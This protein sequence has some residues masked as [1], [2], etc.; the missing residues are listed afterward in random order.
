MRP[1]T[2]TLSAFGPYA[3]CITLSLSALTERGI[4][5]ITGDTGAGKTTLFDAIVYAL[6]G[7]SSGGRREPAMLR[8]KQAE[9]STP[10][11]VELTFSLGEHL[12]TVRRAP[13]YLRPAKRGGEKLISSPPTAELTMPTGEIIVKV[14]DVNA[15]LEELL[16]L[17]R[18]QFLQVAMIA[19]GDFL[20][21]LLAPTDERREI[22][23]RLF[24]TELYERASSLLR[25]EANALSRTRNEEKLLLDQVLAAIRAPDEEDDEEEE[26][27]AD[28]R[29]GALSGEATLA[30]LARLIAKD[31]ARLAAGEAEK[32]AVNA[33]LAALDEEIRC[34]ERRAEAEASLAKTEAALAEAR[35]TVAEA[36]FRLAGETEKESVREGQAA[37]LA[38]LRAAEPALRSLTEKRAAHSTSE[39]ELARVTRAL[40]EAESA[41]SAKGQEL[42]TM[43]EKLD[44]LADAPLAYERALGEFEDLHDRARYITA[45]VNRFCKYDMTGE[46]T[47][48][49]DAEYRALEGERQRAVAHWSTLSSL[50]FANQAGLLAERLQEGMPCPVCG[51]CT[52]PAPAHLSEDAPSEEEVQ[53][54]RETADA[55]AEEVNLKSHLLASAKARHEELARELLAEGEHYFGD[56]TLDEL[57]ARVYEEKKLLAARNVAARN[58]RDSLALACMEREKLAAELPKAELAQTRQNLERDRLLRAREEANVRFV[59]EEG[60]LAEAARALPISDPALLAERIRVLEETL[61]AEKAKQVQAQKLLLAERDTVARLTGECAELRR[62]R[63]SLPAAPLAEKREER[64]ALRVSLNTHEQALR[65]LSTRLSQN[66]ETAASLRERYVRLAAIDERYTRVAAL[67]ATANG[68]IAGKEKLMLETYVQIA[69]FNHVLRR[70]NLRLL[71]MSR[72]RY[73]LA[74]RTLAENNRSQTGLDLDVIDHMAGARRSVKTLSGGESFLASLSL[75]LGLSDEISASSGGIRLDA[76]FIDEGFGSLDEE[77][78]EAAMTALSRLAGESRSIGIISHVSELRERIPRKII[79]RAGRDGGSSAEIVS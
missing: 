54:A 1:L 60:E 37:E 69:Y 39:R 29:R 75:A 16:G 4:Y 40:A 27:L 11:F 19:Q 22:F 66:R 70:A 46:Q 49:F 77:T 33:A 32:Q 30:L 17:T 41:L 28:A 63:D 53:A 72:G 76:M 48:T 18:E 23:R 68:T 59:R 47:V 7:E 12:Y 36:E 52:H 15:R 61:S 79:V 5:L 62:T 10:T 24:S 65:A 35:K 31:E 9:P 26:G 38:R 56:C 21:L 78:L 64:E 13:E 44:A 55:K 14:R 50:Y 71:E 67:S 42:L 45:M 74:R 8:S 58:R 34:A 20:R 2:L 3:D 43:R 57:R 51:A 25:E 6:Y 73:E